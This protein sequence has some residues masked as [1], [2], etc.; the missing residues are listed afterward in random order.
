M[1]EQCLKFVLAQIAK[2]VPTDVELRT[3]LL[4]SGSFARLQEL[5]FG[6]TEA[7]QDLIEKITAAYPEE[8]R[9]F[10]HKSKYK[11][12]ECKPNPVYT[13]RDPIHNIRVLPSKYPI[14]ER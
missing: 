4:L 9:S 8:I 10:Y 3:K 2:L 13:F 14:P 11:V 1:P 6:A 7:V 12:F 5:H